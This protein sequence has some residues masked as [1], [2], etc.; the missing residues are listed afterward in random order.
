MKILSANTGGA[1]GVWRL[2]GMVGSG[3]AVADIICIQEMRM[4]LEDIRVV[5][6]KWSK[7]GFYM[8][9]QRGGSYHGGYGEERE[10]GGVMVLVRKTSKQ[11][12]WGGERL[13][14]NKF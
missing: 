13:S 5:E 4:T 9:K 1:P 7:L 2:I 10:S 3:A 8:Y 12:V 6:L 14:K 11:R